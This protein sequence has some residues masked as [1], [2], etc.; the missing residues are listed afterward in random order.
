MRQSNALEQSIYHSI[1]SNCNTPFW[2]WWWHCFF[3]TNIYFELLLVEKNTTRQQQQ[4]ITS[5]NAC[6]SSDWVI[7]TVS[8]HAVT[9]WKKKRDAKNYFRQILS[10]VAACKKNC[11]SNGNYYFPR[12]KTRSHRYF[13]LLSSCVFVPF[14][15]QFPSSLSSTS[16]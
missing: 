9:G 2:Q 4:K 7:T 15:L 11:N 1:R 3:S 13:F 12:E 14:I 10:R 5:T 16:T 8:R 6:P